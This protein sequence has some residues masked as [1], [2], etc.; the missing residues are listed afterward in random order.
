MSI[1]EVLAEYGFTDTDAKSHRVVV[2]HEEADD[3]LER[4]ALEAEAA[5][6]DLAV[7]EEGAATAAAVA[8]WI[9][10]CGPCA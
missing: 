8:G 9:K 4:A 10:T 7:E 6:V 1:K 2:H 5:A 3:E